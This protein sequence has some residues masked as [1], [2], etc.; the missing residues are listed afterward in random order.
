MK[1]NGWK[2]DPIDIVKM[3]DGIF[4]TVD[5]TRLVSAQ[6]VGVNVQAVAHNYDDLIPEDMAQRFLN[7]KRGCS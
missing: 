5:N 4:T 1:V 6:E 2:G 3:K 7:K